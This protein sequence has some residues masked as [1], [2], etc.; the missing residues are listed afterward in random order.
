MTRTDRAS[1]WAKHLSRQRLGAL[2]RRAYCA[3]HG[4]SVSSLGYWS[5][6]LPAPATD[7]AVTD[8][9]LRLVPVE[10]IAEPGSPMSRGGE[11]ASGIRLHTGA[12]RIELAVG[13]DVPT[14]RRT[15]EALGC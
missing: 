5:R 2:S 14:L 13:F 10:L 4:L 15:L 9:P 7:V 8:A 11:S 3:K 1:F 6:K 12:V